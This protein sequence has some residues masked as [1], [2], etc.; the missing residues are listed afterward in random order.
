M[1]KDKSR[2]GNKLPNK[3]AHSRVSYLYQA[4]NY[5]ATVSQQ[6]REPKKG[7][8]DAEEHGR[9]GE[10]VEDTQ[11][12]RGLNLPSYYASHL[13]AISRRSNLKVS[14]SIKRTICKSCKTLLVPGHSCSILMEN[15]SKNG[16]KPWAD[17]LVTT[18]KICGFKKRMPVGQT[19]VAKRDQTKGN[20]SEDRRNPENRRDPE[21]RGNPENSLADVG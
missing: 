8:Q 3:Q 4:A 13:A 11:P 9:L 20:G 15:L 1:A 6:A 18:C 10:I 5:L 14:S 2:I 17:V 19:R 12:T 7:D 16:K 21:N